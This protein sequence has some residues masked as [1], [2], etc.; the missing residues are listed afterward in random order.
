MAQPV[1]SELNPVQ[2]QSIEDKTLSDRAS[3]PPPPLSLSSSLSSS[4]QWTGC[5]LAGGTKV[6]RSY[7]PVEREKNILFLTPLPDK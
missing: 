6:I 4:V 7:C 3:P 5:L 2:T 1:K